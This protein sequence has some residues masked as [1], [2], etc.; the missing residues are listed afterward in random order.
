LTIAA[1][2]VTS[3][4]VVFG[5][6]STASAYF[7]D[8]GFHY[9]NHNQKI[10]EVGE[11]STLAIATWGLGSIGDLSQRSQIAILADDLAKNNPKSLLDAAN[12][13][14]AQIDKIYKAAYAAEIAKCVALQAK[15]AFN[16][17]VT[18]P[19][20]N[21]RT[22][23]EEVEF[24]NLWYGLSLGFC[25]GGF[26][27][28]NRTPSAAIIDFNPLVNA[29]APSVNEFFS[30]SRFWGAPKIFLRLI[31][32]YD[33]ELR[34]AIINSQKWSGS[35]NEL[36]AILGKM[37]LNHPVLPIRDAIDFIHVCIYTTIKAM[38]FSIM[39]QTCG[40]P[41][42]LATITTDRKFRWV[43]HKDWDSAILDG[44]NR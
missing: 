44:D 36:D 1:C 4:G 19:D 29:A 7:A 6:D 28:L 38:K 8:S 32:G 16:A 11:Q 27:L 12:R 15:P 33:P 3:E 26:V 23:A 9:L 14:A 20:P 24:T 18:P 43:R 34:Q 5:A 21:A 10:F 13:F 37:E 35:H 31:K 22:E 41:I 42:E 17:S 30:G 25:L 39:A 2:Y 40:G